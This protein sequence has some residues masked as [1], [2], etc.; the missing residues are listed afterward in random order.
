MLTFV[1]FVIFAVASSTDVYEM[2]G[3]TRKLDIF[4]QIHLKMFS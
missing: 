2:Q 1:Y 4:F 3:V